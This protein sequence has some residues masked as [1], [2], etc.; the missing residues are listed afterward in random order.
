MGL[1]LGFLDPD[2]RLECL[3]FGWEVTEPR[4]LPFVRWETE[5][6][7]DNFIS[8]FGGNGFCEH[9]GQNHWGTSGALE[10]PKHVL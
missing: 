8:V 3:T 2:S 4:E 10:S 9:F 6:L 1:C 5:S 7:L